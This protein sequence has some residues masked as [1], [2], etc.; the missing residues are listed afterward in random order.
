MFD[1]LRSWLGKHTGAVSIGLKKCPIGRRTNANKWTS[2]ET[3][4]LPKAKASLARMLTAIHS[5]VESEALTL[6]EPTVLVLTVYDADGYQVADL[7]ERYDPPHVEPEVDAVRILADRA[8]ELERQ[9]GQAH[10]M[11]I[12]ANRVTTEA[13]VAMAEN[14]ARAV[15]NT[16]ALLQVMIEQRLKDGEGSDLSPLLT[17]VSGIVEVM[18]LRKPGPQ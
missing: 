6:T 7:S 8:K 2:V 9:L 16:T 4:A 3:W 17:A 18:A 12:E 10:S 14:Q 15:G 1:T 11:L 13:M 5:T